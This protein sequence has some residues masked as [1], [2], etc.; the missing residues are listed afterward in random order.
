MN[1]HT[2]S[3]L[4]PILPAVTNMV[5]D[6]ASFARTK[7]AMWVVFGVA[8]VMRIIYF[9][10]A[11]D[12]PLLYIQQLDEEFY[13]N[14]GKSLISDH[15]DDG[16]SKFYMDPLYGFFLGGIYYLFGDNLLIPRLIQ[17][18]TDSFAALLM[19]LIGRRLW[20]PTAGLGAGII[21]AVYPVSWFYSLTLL[22]T[23]FTTDFV[24]LFTYL[25]IL[26]L[27]Q[28]NL[29]NWF[30]LG[31]VTGI[32]VYLRGNLIL[33]LPATVLLPLLCRK[34]S[35]KKAVQLAAFYLLG[36]SLILGSV[37]LIN[38]ST[39][40][41]FSILPNTGGTTL[42]GA[43]NPEN[44]YGEN[45]NPKFI[46]RNHPSDIYTQ[47]KVE[48][49][50]RLNRTLSDKEVSTFWR[51]EAM[52]YWFSSFSVLP[53]LL[54][55]KFKHLISHKEI[56]NNQ[57]IEIAA[58]FAPVL[59]PQVPYFSLVLAF[60][61]PGLLLALRKDKRVYAL[62]PVI[63]VVLVTSLI[64]FSSSRFRLPMVPILIL[65]S[66]YYF[67]ALRSSPGDIKK[68]ILLVATAII[69]LVSINVHGPRD[70]IAQQD[71]N[72]ALAHAEVSETDKAIALIRQ[73]ESEMSDDNYYQKIRGYI[74]LLAKDYNSAYHYSTLAIKQDPD[75][76]GTM[77][78]AGIAALEQN[79]TQ[80]ALN[81]FKHALQI[82]NDTEMHYWIG[83]SY[84]QLG[85]KEKAK[86][87]LTLAIDTLPIT[88]QIAM[89]AKKLLQQLQAS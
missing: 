55:H 45:K 35:L 12:N 70:N 4:K 69:F 48:A 66:V 43:N 82:S 52:K 88:S 67:Y 11:T 39:F 38:K 79:D 7:K 18:V 73:H 76:Y 54:L 27:G 30:V 2:N 23:T 49:E 21:Y 14:Y 71:I 68:Y 51:G 78:V 86:Q 44:P 77:S 57:S 13:S 50:K 3:S 36:A 41:T 25:L 22:K 62:L 53:S 24:I 19:Y 56:A 29:R 8:M 64:Y 87:H 72:L 34:D 61:L 59:F 89:E 84:N 63:F 28:Q 31:I 10:Q 46:T 20:S 81:I 65:G 17:I 9:L 74:S 60:G 85:E 42:Y 16:T 26:F 15:P 75:D 37:G 32:G 33:L 47:Y 83:K 80:N 40:G 6:V 1:L 58:R 5:R